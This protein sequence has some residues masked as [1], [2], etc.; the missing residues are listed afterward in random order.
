MEQVYCMQNAFSPIVFS[1]DDKKTEIM[2][3]NAALLH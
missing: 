2:W 1:E 3:S